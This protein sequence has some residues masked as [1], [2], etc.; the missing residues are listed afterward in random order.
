MK[1]SDSNDRSTSDCEDNIHECVAIYGPNL[2]KAKRVRTGELPQT[3]TAK[4]MDS[5]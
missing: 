1:G 3:H 4:L 5:H 2:R